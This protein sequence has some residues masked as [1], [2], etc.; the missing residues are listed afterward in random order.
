MHQPD[1]GADAALC[2]VGNVMH[3]AVMRSC[4]VHLLVA[5]LLAS[6]GART[7]VHANGDAST[8]AATVCAPCSADACDVLVDE[9]IA[10]AFAGNDTASIALGEGGRLFVLLEEP[11]AAYQASIY[12]RVAPGS[13]QRIDGGVAATG[14]LA[15]DP[16]PWAPSA[17]GP[18]ACVLYDGAYHSLLEATAAHTFPV[19]TDESVSSPNVWRD[20]VG[21]VHFVSEGG[22]GHGPTPPTYFTFD[23]TFHATPLSRTDARADGGRLALGARDVAWLAWTEP[24]SSTASPS[25]LFAW[26]SD[27]QTRESVG[28]VHAGVGPIAVADVAGADAPAIVFSDPPAMLLALARRDPSGAWPR[29]ELVTDCETPCAL[30]MRTVTMVASGPHLVVLYAT[31]TRGPGDARTTTLFRADGASAPTIVFTHPAADIVGVRAIA[32]ASC[33]LHVAYDEIDATNGVTSTRYVL[34]GAP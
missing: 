8:P 15:I 7:A 24:S 30:D 14:A 13:W 26:R 27:T 9:T 31:T 34:L 3:A 29:T 28:V 6:C 25:E 4:D 23:G 33:H 10:P 22:T 12:E 16:P 19:L 20:S 18:Y 32:D 11:T 21:T 17:L 2:P 5:M 1:G